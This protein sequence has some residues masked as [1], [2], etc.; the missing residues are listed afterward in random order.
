MSDDE[1]SGSLLDVLKTVKEGKNRSENPSSQTGGPSANA[2]PTTTGS[3]SEVMNIL[4]P[5]ARPPAAPAPAQNL[6]YPVGGGPKLDPGQ[7]VTPPGGTTI[8]NGGVGDIGASPAA[9]SVLGLIDVLAIVKNDDIA[10]H[11]GAK[12]DL[13]DANRT[14]P[15]PV[16]VTLPSGGK[17]SIRTSMGDDF[18]TRSVV[19]TGPD[20]QPYVD[21]DSTTRRFNEPILGFGT[22]FDME[23][24]ADGNP[25]RAI[26]YGSSSAK[27]ILFGPEGLTIVPLDPKQREFKLLPAPLDTGIIAVNGTQVGSLEGVRVVSNTTASEMQTGA[28]WLDRYAYRLFP[29][30]I[31]NV[32][33]ATRDLTV[34]APGGKSVPLGVGR[35][36]GAIGATTLP[37]AIWGDMQGG[38]SFQRAS[39]REGTGL[40][41]GLALSAAT[42]AGLGFFAGGV[43]AV[44]GFFAGLIAGMA[45]S[46]AGSKAMDYVLPPDFGGPDGRVENPPP[47]WLLPD[48]PASLREYIGALEQSEPEKPTNHGYVGRGPANYDSYNT[49]KY[50]HDE[51]QTQIDAAREKLGQVENPKAEHRAAGGY[52]SGPGGSTD[53]L[54]PAWLSNGEYVVNASATADNLPILQAINSG[55]VPSADLL[56]G[57][58]PGFSPV[59]WTGVYTTPK[60]TL[61]PAEWSSIM[62]PQPESGGSG[63]DLEALIESSRIQP[64]KTLESPGPSPW[65][66]KTLELPGPSLSVPDD[67][68]QRPA[69]SDENAGPFGLDQNVLARGFL[70]GAIAG[71]KGGPFGMLGGGVS[72]LA[73]TAG[74][75]I[76]TAIGTALMPALGPAAPLGPVIGE[77]LGSTI[78]QMGAE[79][80]LEPVEQVVG[81]AADT[82]KEV[83]GNGFGLVDLAEGPGGYTPRQDIYN[84]NGMDPKSAAIAVERVR[85]R[86]SLAQ[87]RGGGLGR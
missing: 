18:Y 77:A 50:L 23:E 64:I 82:A 70:E 61:D 39:V 21:F 71:A 43:G 44:P 27:E 42:G 40:L 74:G 85:R 31:D 65:K 48:D 72:G 81:Y 45:G 35:L 22:H 29:G 9:P 32:E 63:I 7:S 2:A 47:T 41:T 15:R 80:L 75:A 87:Q 54:I 24:D 55:W 84:F 33:L 38:D 17:F 13:S 20:G 51:W 76:G 79:A 66:L 53:D 34:T 62:P 68:R 3:S 19:M 59:G 16:T 86:R 12:I 60:R 26:I 14:N 67:S 6:P 37:L 58:V 56:H 25:K 49:K 4:V 78:G 5:Q 28:N 57:L 36:S 8:H 30:A 73:V 52:I 11:T 1:F 10:A 83:I 46:Y 69:T